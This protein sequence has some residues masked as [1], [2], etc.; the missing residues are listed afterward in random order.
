MEACRLEGNHHRNPGRKGVPG[1]GNG[2]GGGPEAGGYWH[3]QGAALRPSNIA[4][5]GEG[6][7]AHRKH[8]S[9][10]GWQEPEPRKPVGPGLHSW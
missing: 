8:A 3:V 10:S 4:R 1:R 5:N 7:G 9:L 2:E 6:E